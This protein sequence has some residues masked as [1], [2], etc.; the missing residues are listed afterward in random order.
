MY[1]SDQIADTM[2]RAF[3]RLP[4]ALREQLILTKNEQSFSGLWAWEFEKTLSNYGSNFLLLENKG[5][6]FRRSSDKRSKKTMNFHDIS[7]VD[8]NGAFLMIVE[9]K[10]WYHFD[11]AKGKKTPKLEPQVKS[12]IKSDISKIKITLKQN[13]VPAI[14]YLLINLVTPAQANLLPISYLNFHKNALNRTNG[15]LDT[16]I[17]DGVDAIKQQLTSSKFSTAEFAH[18]KSIF[19]AENGRTFLDTF[20]V[21]VVL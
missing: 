17:S 12:Q 11:G 19:Q 6:S 14:G 18:S 5:V 3:T 8:Q 1:S 7:L 13:K 10:I 20:C 15:N 2:T 21:R 16:Y 9:N 4:E